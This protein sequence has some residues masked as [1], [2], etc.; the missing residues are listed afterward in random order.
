MED[1]KLKY[2]M[3]ALIGILIGVIVGT[4]LSILTL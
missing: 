4:I 1:K 3:S 2:Y